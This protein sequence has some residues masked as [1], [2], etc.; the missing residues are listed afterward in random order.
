MSLL[1]WLVD[2]VNTDGESATRSTTGT[3]PAKAIEFAIKRCMDYI[4]SQSHED[5]DQEVEKV[6]THQWDQFVAWYYKIIHGQS[7]FVSGGITFHVIATVF[8][9]NKSFKQIYSWKTFWFKIE[10]R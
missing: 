9:K 5:I 10:T 2:K 7:L 3:V 8:Y 1:K 4:K 6:W